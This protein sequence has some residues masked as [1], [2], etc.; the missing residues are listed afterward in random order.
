MQDAASDVGWSRSRSKPVREGDR[1][2]FWE[3]RAFNLLPQGGKPD[4]E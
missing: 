3:Q 2:A 1:D 4:K